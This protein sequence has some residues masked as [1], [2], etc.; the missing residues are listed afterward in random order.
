M[1]LFPVISPYTG[2]KAKG[3]ESNIA[4]LA[5]VWDFMDDIRIKDGKE[6]KMLVKE[7]SRFP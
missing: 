7:W 1:T 5:P 2:K 4:A 6:S 3:V